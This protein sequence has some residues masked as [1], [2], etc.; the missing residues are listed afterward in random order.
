MSLCISGTFYYVVESAE[1][2][3]ASASAHAPSLQHIA[4]W[5][6]AVAICDMYIGSLC[7]D[8]A[9][10]LYRV[11]SSGGVVVCDNCY[12]EVTAIEPTSS[13]FNDK[14]ALFSGV[15]HRCTK[16]EEVIEA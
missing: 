15:K 13:C 12:G 5:C 4:Q 11:D 16:S 7:H 2:A 8:G 1:E 3:G 6:S 14:D 10:R 9:G